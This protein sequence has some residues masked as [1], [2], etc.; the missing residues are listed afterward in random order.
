MKLGNKQTKKGK[1]A[2]LTNTCFFEKKII[3]KDVKAVNYKLK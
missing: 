1:K 3:S 2:K